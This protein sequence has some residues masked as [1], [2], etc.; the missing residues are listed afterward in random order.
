MGD[1]GFIRGGQFH[2]LFYAG[3]PLRERELGVDVPVTFKELDVGI[4]E[5]VQ[6][7]QPTVSATPYVQF[8]TL[9]FTP[10]GHI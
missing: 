7:R 10:F 3:S 8:H 5:P 6:P 9:S 1:V 4:P 2:L